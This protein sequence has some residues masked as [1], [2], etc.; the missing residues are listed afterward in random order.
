MQ[1]SVG[2]ARIETTQITRR[3]LDCRLESE[4]EDVTRRDGDDTGETA[5]EFGR[6]LLEGGS[7]RAAHVGLSAAAG[8]KS[9]L[10]RGEQL[11]CGALTTPTCH[12]G[13]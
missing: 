5:D 8:R 6:K 12:T 2:L 7:D 11:K 4:K 1:A 3:A 10:Q 9:Q 13:S